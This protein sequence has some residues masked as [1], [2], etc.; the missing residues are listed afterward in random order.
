MYFE[1]RLLNFEFGTLGARHCPELPY[2]D[3]SSSVR[4]QN[5]KFKIA[6]MDIG[7]SIFLKVKDFS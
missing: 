1:F 5:S 7:S 4:I 2:S 3:G 6:G